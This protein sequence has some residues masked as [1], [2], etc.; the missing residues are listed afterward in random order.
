MK[1]ARYLILGAG[2]QG[3][4]IAYDLVRHG[5]P[6]RVVLADSQEEIAKEAAERVNRLAG[7]ELARAA[8]CNAAHV[9][10]AQDLM[11]DA[12]VVVS[13][14]P[15]RLNAALARAAIQ[16]K[17]HFTDLG[18]NT[19]IVKQE[20]AL[21]EE[22]EA[23]G[24]SVVPDLGLA[25]GMG[26]ILAAWAIRQLDAPEEVV[27]RCGGLPQHPRPPLHYK[28]VFSV[29]G[30][31]N[32]YSGMG[33][34]LAD[35]EIVQVPTLTQPEEI[36]VPGVGRLEARVTSGGTSTCPET[37]H[38]K[39]RTYNYKTLRYPG[40]FELMAAAKTLGFL[41]E[42]P[43]LVG[44]AK[45]AP[46]V[47]LHA[48][49]ARECSYEDEDLVVLRVAA[50]GTKD[51]KRRTLTLDLVDRQDA[52]TG[53][54]AMERTTGF[55]TSIV[56]IMMARGEIPPGARPPELSVPG[57][58]FLAALGERGLAPEQTWT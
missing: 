55:P 49:L 13:A 23:A 54:T 20:L 31:T 56:A 57:G 26:N 38:G 2:R 22:A 40:H 19:D 36:D 39:L 48:L 58:P 6:G 9:A 50:T 14:V 46:R 16:A 4:A 12:D 53:F 30:L 29:H 28:L 37:F 15:Y 34:A 45:V 3:T 25:P 27:I 43:V 10:E 41:D 42:E 5:A 51:G 8:V 21:H 52:E 35:G 44:D 1:G 33:Q 47:M 24:I 7:G 32:E 11:G 17:T 18:G